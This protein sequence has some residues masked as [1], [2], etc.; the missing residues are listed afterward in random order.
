MLFSLC[1]SVAF[2]TNKSSIL[3]NI[4]R[5]C[6]FISREHKILLMKDLP[7][8]SFSSSFPLNDFYFPS[9]VVLLKKV[10]LTFLREK[11]LSYWI[12]E[13]ICI[14]EYKKS[15]FDVSFSFFNNIAEIA[16]VQMRI[17]LFLLHIYTWILKLILNYTLLIER[18]GIRT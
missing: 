3:W 14:K 13:N 16:L 5:W 11:Y 1:V 2:K 9:I 12:Q 18:A 10:A 7:Q 17:I 8:S 4:I 6:D 15:K